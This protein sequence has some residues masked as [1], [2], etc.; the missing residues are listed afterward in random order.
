MRRRVIGIDFSADAKYAGRKTRVAFG[1]IN[2]QRTDILDCFTVPGPPAREAA[3]AALV[4]FIGDQRDV[5]IGMD[6]PFALPAQ[7]M[8][9]VHWP[10]FVLGFGAEH[11]DP[12]AYRATCM[13]RAAGKEV[14]RATDIAACAPFAG[15][16]IRIKTMAFHGIRDVLA[17]LIENDLARVHPFQHPAADKPIVIEI[18]PASTLN[19]LGLYRKHRGYKSSDRAPRRRILA[20]ILARGLLGPLPRM[21][22]RDVIEDNGGDVLDAVVAACGVA[23][24]V[25]S[26]AL[27]QPVSASQ[28]LEGRLYY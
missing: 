4:H 26:G 5:V 6:F 18:C 10:D 16:N 8:G 7:V 23:E 28:R 15:Y 1:E 3:L 12:E 25:R 13:R 17:P 19:R 14:K 9:T 11:A 2:G 27:E 21:I 20:E 24:A 22:E